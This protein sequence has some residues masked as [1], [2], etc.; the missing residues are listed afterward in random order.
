M[1]LMIPDERIEALMKVAQSGCGG[2]YALDFAHEYMAETY[3]V[4]G[5]LMMDRHRLI[6]ALELLYQCNPSEDSDSW[7]TARSIAGEA[8]LFVRK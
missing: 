2:R 4:L 8:L 1:M 6:H 3:G 5:R 7:N